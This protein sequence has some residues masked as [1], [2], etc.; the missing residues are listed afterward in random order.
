MARNRQRRQANAARFAR[1][2]QE[3]YVDQILAQED[4]KKRHAEFLA[5]L[6]VQQAQVLSR[7]VEVYN[8][9]DLTQPENL[10]ALRVF[11]ERMYGPVESCV[12]IK[13][14]KR[15][16]NGNNPNR[17]PG[18]QRYFPPARVRFR[19]AIDAE[20]IFCGTPLDQ[21][22]ESA[23]VA[24]SLGCKDG[25]Y[26]SISP[27]KP[28]SNMLTDDESLRGEIILVDATSLAMGHWC[29]EDADMFLSSFDDDS[30]TRGDGET[31]V[32]EAP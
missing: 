18:S 10:Y 14:V 26:I 28:Y 21:V 29:P 9:K 23:L 13:P 17:R 1:L 31:W 6:K 8:V 25:R 4:A 5:S 22:R 15:N 16:R 12:P 3:Q 7:T 30:V 11:M 2:R 32:Q 27:S 19:S 20:R 24:C